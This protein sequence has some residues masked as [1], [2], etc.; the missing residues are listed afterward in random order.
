MNGMSYQP[1]TTTHATMERDVFVLTAA[2]QI[3]YFS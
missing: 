2:G 1:H 3:P